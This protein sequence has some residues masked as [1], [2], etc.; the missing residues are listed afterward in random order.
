MPLPEPNAAESILIGTAG[1]S[2]A[3]MASFARRGENA[4][5]RPMSLR[6]TAAVV[7]WSKIN[8]T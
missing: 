3:E 5:G 4:L 1:C 7:L 8:N 6:R 2:Q